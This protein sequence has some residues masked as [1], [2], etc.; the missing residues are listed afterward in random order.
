[1]RGSFDSGRFDTMR[2]YLQVPSAIW[3]FLR[4]TRTELDLLLLT[5]IVKSFKIIGRN[6]RRRMS[7]M[8]VDLI[9]AFLREDVLGSKSVSLSSLHHRAHECNNA[10]G[11]C[12]KAF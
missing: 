6:M 5:D 4:A 10:T 9:L 7:S 1:M 12:E 2:I 8:N 3:N 11:H